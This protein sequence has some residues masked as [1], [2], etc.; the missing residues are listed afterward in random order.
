MQINEFIEATARLEKYYDKEYPKDK[1]KIMHEE[2]QN[3]SIER[4]KFLISK[5]IRKCKFLPRV[6]DFVQIDLEFPEQK[7]EEEKE[8]ISCS[9][10]NSTGIVVYTKKI[11]NG[12][13]A[14]VCQY[15]AIC[16]CGNHKQY[17]GWENKEHKSDYYTPM[18][19]ELG[20]I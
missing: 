12:N 15:A 8:I 7:I 18:A 13:E 1:L 17:K 11:P 4:Y 9:K 3:F 5:A 2:L 20:L 14:L 6:C 10:C 16:D 19:K